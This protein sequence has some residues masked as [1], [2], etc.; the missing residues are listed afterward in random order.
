MTCPL[1]CLITYV[2]LF[3]NQISIFAKNINIINMCNT[4]V[5]V[6]II[7]GNVPKSVVMALR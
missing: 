5:V 4:V 1:Y 7:H 3:P 2:V 6:M